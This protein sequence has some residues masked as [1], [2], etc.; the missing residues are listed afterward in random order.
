MV[1][2]VAFGDDGVWTSLATETGFSEFP[3]VLEGFGF[4]PGLAR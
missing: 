3:L 2:I 1:D 4:N